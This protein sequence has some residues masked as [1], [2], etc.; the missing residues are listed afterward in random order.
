[1]IMC[2]EEEKK[3][4]IGKI[5]WSTPEHSI[6]NWVCREIEYRI[7]R[8]IAAVIAALTPTGATTVFLCSSNSRPDASRLRRREWRRGTDGRH[9]R[10]SK[11]SSPLRFQKSFARSDLEFLQRC[12]ARVVAE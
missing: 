5:R 11:S 8:I 3:K 6:E 2:V 10:K 12:L 1:M 4:K 7:R 9:F